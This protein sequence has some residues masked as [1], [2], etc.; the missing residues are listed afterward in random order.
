VNAGR[1]TYNND[2]NEISG[3]VGKGNVLGMP[4]N[5]L[6]I[7]STGHAIN[8]TA[9]VAANMPTSD[10]GITVVI[11]GVIKTPARAMSA[12]PTAYALSSGKW[13]MDSIRFR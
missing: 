12:V 4:P 9:A 5:L 11:R 3:N 10:P 7:V 13:V 2:E 6:P 1:N 8:V